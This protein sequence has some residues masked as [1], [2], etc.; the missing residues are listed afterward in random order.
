MLA[1][2]KWDFRA[3]LGSGSGLSY[4]YKLGL[5]QAKQNWGLRWAG[6]DQNCHG[7][8]DPVILA[9]VIEVVNVLTVA[10]RLA[11]FLI[12]VNKV[13]DCILEQR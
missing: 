1:L 7:S 9:M 5:A 2:K 11:I 8:T 6:L 3:E 4:I 10:T 12:F 13:F